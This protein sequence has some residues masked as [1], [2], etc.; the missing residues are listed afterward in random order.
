M[1]QSHL[2]SAV[3]CDVLCN[4]QFFLN[5]FDDKLLMYMII[6]NWCWLINMYGRCQSHGNPQNLK[7]NGNSP[8]SG[9][10]VP[11]FHLWHWVVRSQPVPAALPFMRWSKTGQFSVRFGGCG[12]TTCCRDVS[13][14][15]LEAHVWSL[16]SGS[17]P[18]GGKHSKQ[19][20]MIIRNNG[21]FLRN[22]QG[23]GHHGDQDRKW[24]L[25]V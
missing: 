5:D 10:T 16:L 11:S 14:G 9:H 8:S 25:G 18:R 17:L 13:E 6:I 3:H 24:G 12:A 21:P 19:S 22:V 23:W 20:N 4:K 7:V 1:P 2:M 15:Q